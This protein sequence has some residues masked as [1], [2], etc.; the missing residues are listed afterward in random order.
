MESELFRQYVIMNNESRRLNDSLYLEARALTENLTKSV[1]ELTAQISSISA[2][3]AALEGRVGEVVNQTTQ[4]LES[5]RNDISTVSTANDQQNTRINSNLQTITKV[6]NV[7]S[8]LKY[9]YCV[10]RTVLS[11]TTDANGFTRIDM[12]NFPADIISKSNDYV[13]AVNVYDYRVSDY[14]TLVVSM[15]DYSN[16]SYL[17]V[18]VAYYSG[19]TF[20]GNCRLQ[21][22]YLALNPAK[23]L[24]L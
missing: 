5:V 18:R 11:Q 7:V 14:N 4:S 15:C 16:D 20:T 10:K 13:I 19:K 22:W 21:A 3:L 6:S 2:R 1:K 23:D 17:N 12:A 9:L 8:S 24:P